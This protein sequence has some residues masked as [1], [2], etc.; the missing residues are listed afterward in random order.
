MA[1]EPYIVGQQMAYSSMLGQYSA[2]IGPIPQKQIKKIAKRFIESLR[3]EIKEWHG[4]I[5]KD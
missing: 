2:T 1:L 4:N 5:L 3:E